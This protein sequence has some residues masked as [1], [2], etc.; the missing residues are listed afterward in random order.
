[1]LR[2]R[3]LSR[4]RPFLEALEDRTLLSYANVL[5]NS[6][7]A[8][9]GTNDTQSETSVVAA[10][11]TVVVAFN[12][13]GSNQSNNKFTGFGRSTDGGATFTDLGT[14]PASTAGDAGDPALARDN[15][16]G[17]LYLATLGYS[18]SN[19]IQVFRSTDGG[20]TWAA[21][22]NGAPGFSSGHQLDKEWLAVDNA[23]GAGQ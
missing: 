3:W 14:L 18:S 21:P 8:D 9:T 20:A 7:A 19:V 10:G 5:V 23:A 11:S 4:H 1:M 12:D 22:V 2:T 16:S 15:V 6:P 17:K 13:S